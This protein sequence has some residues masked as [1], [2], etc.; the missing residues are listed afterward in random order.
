MREYS[1]LI[2]GQAGDGINQ[3]GLLL[4]A[5]FTQMGYRAYM[6][7]DYPSLIRGGHNFAIVRCAER[8]VYAHHDR[9]DLVIALNQETVD[10]HVHRL[11]DPHD[12]SLTQA[13]QRRAAQA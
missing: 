12:I 13:R 6:Y 11:E 3:A 4:T 7:F 5:I 10:L 9:M 1:V 2:G 8:K